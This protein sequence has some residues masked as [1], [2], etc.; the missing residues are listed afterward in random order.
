MESVLVSACLMGQAVRFD[1]AGRFC[2]HAVLRRWRDEGRIV[3]AC[4]EV[5]GGLPVPRPRA[6]IAAAAGGL[7]VLLGTAKV[8]NCEGQDVSEYFVHGARKTL[9]LV[10]E[11]GIRIAI[12]KENSPS[13]GTGNIY[14]GTFSGTRI[15]GLGV[16]AALLQNNGVHVFGESGIFEA[17]RLLRKLEG[18]FPPG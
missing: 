6:E 5:A 8:I 18:G 16:T 13:C 12:L 1:G 11:K 7:K 9:R 10:Q 3:E 15:A 17:E 2:D 14:D 4:P